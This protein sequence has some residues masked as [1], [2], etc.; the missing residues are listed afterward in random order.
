MKTWPGWRMRNASSS[1]AFGLSG[2]TSPSRSSRRPPR[3]AWT[4]PEVDD[5]RRGLD[6]DRL[7]RAAEQRADPGGQL[8]QAERLG[9]VVVGAELEA[10]DLVELG[11]LGRQ[12][13]D[14]HARLGPDDPADLDPGQLG[15]HQV[16]EDEVRPLGA[17]P[18]QRLAPVGRRTTRKP[19]VSSA[20][21]SA[22]R[23]VGSSS[24]TRIVRAICRS[25]YRRVLTGRFA[26]D[27]PAIR[28]TTRAQPLRQLHE[29]LD[30]LDALA[31]AVEAQ[32]EVVVVQRLERAVRV[33][34]TGSRRPRRP[35]RRRT[36]TRRSGRS[37]SPGSSLFDSQ[38]ATI[39]SR[40]TTG[41][42]HG[43]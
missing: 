27:H 25:G 33:R 23:R 22:S 38:S 35:A 31:V 8:A 21:T 7:V 29:V 18:D 11:I 4:G 28:S 34:C 39:A 6:R 17:E 12:H 42:A 15:E 2:T 26:P 24:T 5:G 43:W 20:S 19:S 36:P 32:L 30:E 16:E 3:S 1:N 37:T 10:D 13:H 40:P 14:R 41:S 9:D